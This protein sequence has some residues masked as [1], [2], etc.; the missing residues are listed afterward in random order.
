MVIYDYAVQMIK[1]AQPSRKRTSAATCDAS[2]MPPAKRRRMLPADR[3]KEI[4]EEAVRFFAEVGFDGTLRELAVRLGITHQNLFRY[5]PTKEALIDRVYREVYL[6]R[7]QPEWETM[8][9][10]PGKSLEA[11]L[12]DFYKAYLHAIFRYDWVR[13]FVF[14]GLKGVGISQRYLTLIQT[15]L[16]EPLA[17]EL[18][19]MSCDAQAGKA[20]SADELEVAWGLHGEL[21]YLAVRRWIYDMP[22]PGDLDALIENTIA[23][24]FHGAPA[25]MR[26]VHE[27][28]NGTPPASGRRHSDSA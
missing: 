14:A 20:L 3:E 8:L 27:R 18:R 5:F 22:V 11:R 24:F 6:S 25:V 10:Q 26:A 17:I 16:I 9:Q 12:T 13:I 19:S 23:R 7:W 1:S 4:V 2:V 21:F 28:A 15:R